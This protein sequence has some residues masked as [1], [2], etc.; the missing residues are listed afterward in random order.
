MAGVKVEADTEVAVDTSVAI[1]A[2]WSEE[3]MFTAEK[4][5]GQRNCT[6][7]EI[8]KVIYSA[9]NVGD[10]LAQRVYRLVTSDMA[11]DICSI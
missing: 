2:I 1:L 7:M 5:S 8:L 9:N 4:S 10:A 6:R 3:L 11:L